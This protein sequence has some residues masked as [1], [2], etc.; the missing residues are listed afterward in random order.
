MHISVGTFNVNN[1]F[2]RFNFE[3]R[4]E[5][6]KLPEGKVPFTKI[7]QIVD[8]VGAEIVQYEGWAIK[9]KDPKDR[10]E[11]AERIKAM[12]L[13]ILALQEVEDIE[14]L[15]YFAKHDLGGLYPHVM[16]LEGND[17][18]LIDVAVLS[19]Y[20]I[21]K[22]TTWQ[23][24]VNPP[25]STD[26][27]FSRDLLQVEILNADRSPL[28]TLFVNHLKSDFVPFTED[29]EA[30]LKAANERRRLQAET[31]ALI[32]E[33][34]LPPDARYI[35]LGDMNDAPDSA[36]LRPLTDNF[37]LN[38]VD[39]LASAEQTRPAPKTSTALPTKVWTYRYKPSGKAAQYVLYDQ[40]WLSQSLAPKQTKAFIDRRT[41]MT[42]DG[43]DHDPAWIELEL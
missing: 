31:A 38:L 15:R 26:R 8:D 14:T 33:H 25:T 28:F 7:R 9:R 35:V 1:L 40:I 21:G 18:R 4:A 36:F 24:A 5:V 39:G 2:S 6:E 42:G 20:P 37:D 29:Q 13:D 11:V 41:K 27:V 32:I 30:G 12:S 10:A 34:A 17:S 16:L 43:S 3:L 19:K 22:T 23:T